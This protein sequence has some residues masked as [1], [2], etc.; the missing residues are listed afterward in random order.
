M[1]VIKKN[2]K[3]Y[4]P[5][6]NDFLHFANV[7]NKNAALDLRGTQGLQDSKLLPVQN[8][9]DTNSA[10]GALTPKPNNIAAPVVDT[11][12]KY[13]SDAVTNDKDGTN[14]Q[15]ITAEETVT[16]AD[17]PSWEKYK[18]DNG[19]LEES[20]WYASYGL[21]PERDYQNT[22]NTLNYEYQTSMATYG[23]NAE[24]LYQMGLQNSG[25]SDIFQS[26]AFS[27]YLANMNAA[28]AAKIAAKKQNKALYNAYI[29]EK[30]G[31]YNTY[32]QAWQ[33]KQD[34]RMTNALSAVRGAGLTS[35]STDDSIRYVLESSGISNVT[36]EDVASVKSKLGE[37]EKIVQTE[38]DRVIKQETDDALV[39]IDEG[40]VKLQNAD[41]ANTYDDYIKA[42]AELDNLLANGYDKE[43]I[44]A[45]REEYRVN[46]VEVINSIMQ[47]DANNV[48]NAYEKLGSFLGISKEDWEKM[49]TEDQRHLI[50]KNAGE[51]V[52]KKDGITKYE[53]NAL[54]SVWIDK[55]TQTYIDTDNQNAEATGL[56]DAGDL[57]YA[58]KE[59]KDKGYLSE[60]E[61][62]A[63]IDQIISKMQFNLRGRG[64]SW[65]GTVDGAEVSLYHKIFRTNYDTLGDNPPASGE[66]EKIYEETGNTIVTVNGDL[67]VRDEDHGT[68][69]ILTTKD[70]NVIG[71]NHTNTDTESKGIHE[72]FVRLLENEQNGKPSVAEKKA[73]DIIDKR[74]GT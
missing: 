45:K 8:P 15:S 9:M 39:S 55:E 27:T 6:Q 46:R 69:E 57:A 35:E 66:L 1:A 10:G 48:N 33:A 14:S 28:A 2:L 67:Y 20:D 7:M 70:Y 71:D 19:V 49:N 16:S 4:V 56:A 18:A 26:N 40:L 13:E 12:N 30:Q 72:I 59:L 17:A 43:T 34:A 31:N 61:Y 50:I 22:V 42:E 53:Y 23:Q 52:G 51:L 54:V 11:N 47:G 68:W 25:V 29:A 5:G 58:L 44:E 62:K 37:V 32:A 63:K 38:N 65:Y 3:D 73:K 74:F 60:E 36:N 21:D 64:I 41:G 24:N